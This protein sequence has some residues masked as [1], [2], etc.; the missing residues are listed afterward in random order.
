MQAEQLKQ[1]NMKLVTLNTRLMEAEENK[2]NYELYIIRM[3][4]ED[5]QLGKQIDHLRSICAEYSR[6]L[7]KLEKMNKRVGLQR[8]EVQDETNRFV[9][10]VQ[11]FMAFADSVVTD[12][13]R[14]LNASYK[15]SLYQEQLFH[16]RA[17]RLERLRR[18]KVE[19]LKQTYAVLQQQQAEL[20]TDM[21]GWDEKVESYEKRFRKVAAAT[22]LTRAEQIISKFYFNDEITQDLNREIAGKERTLTQLREVR[23]QLQSALTESKQTLAVS[24][25]KDVSEAEERCAEA[26]LSLSRQSEECDKWT[27][28]ITQVVEGMMQLS[29]KVQHRM[30]QGAEQA[31]YSDDVDDTAEQDREAAALDEEE[32]RLNGKEEE[33]EEKD[34]EEEPEEGE[35]EDGEE[36]GAEAGDSASPAMVVT[37]PTT[38]GEALESDSDS[39]DVEVLDV[40]RLMNEV[41]IATAANIAAL[42]QP[43]TA[44]DTAS[45]GA[46]AALS[47]SRHRSALPRY[48]HIGSRQQ[49][50]STVTERAVRRT[51]QRMRQWVDRLISAVQEGREQQKERAVRRA[52]IASEEA[53]KSELAQRT[54]QLQQMLLNPRK[55]I[56]DSVQ[57]KVEINTVE[58]NEISNLREKTGS[59]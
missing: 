45:P 31:P 21:D 8:L 6:L 51:E 2:K 36:E 16:Q 46:L 12:Y 9:Q 48:P 14:V 23:Q 49:T 38:S 5:L 28:R 4:E 30:D 56:W 22:G 27:H 43:H 32:R 18:D 7:T 29:N 17:E 25:W 35:E 59:A 53:E 3:K 1:L 37:A 26:K 33:E 11:A 44:L 39:E 34:A 52:A 47:P 54:E 13:R 24:K 40:T 10:D 55:N 57:E 15:Q 41:A 50:A 42:S 58:E 19:A 20:K